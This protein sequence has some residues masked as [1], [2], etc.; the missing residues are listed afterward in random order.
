MFTSSNGETAIV[1]GAG[2]ISISA[3]IVLKFF[4]CKKVM[5]V[6]LSD[7]RLERCKKLGF[8]TCNSS[9]ENLKEKAMKVFGKARRLRDSQCRY[10]Y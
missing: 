4:G 10:L 8:E 5:V 9:K 6:N 7:F 3:A 2:A 1:F